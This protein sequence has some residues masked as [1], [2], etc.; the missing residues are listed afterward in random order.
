MKQSN[1]SFGNHLEKGSERRLI[2]RDERQYIIHFL[3]Q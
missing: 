3:I 2:H 1:G